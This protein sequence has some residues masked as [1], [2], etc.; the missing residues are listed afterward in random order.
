MQPT[1]TFS[2]V[3]Q[4]CSTPWATH[5]LQCFLGLRHC[6]KF[7]FASLVC[8]KMLVK[9]QLLGS[10]Q[11]GWDS[12]ITGCVTPTDPLARQSI[13]LNQLR[14]FSLKPFHQRSPAH[15]IGLPCQ[16]QNLLWRLPISAPR[17]L[18][19]LARNGTTSL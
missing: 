14:L 1:M 17:S 5:D 3:Q 7:S 2:S 10:F 9:K 4:S 18:D 16:M 13:V 8:K 19:R 6:Q 12:R 11:Y 15:L